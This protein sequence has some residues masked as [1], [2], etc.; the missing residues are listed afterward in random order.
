M[1][2]TKRLRTF[3]VERT[4]LKK[5]DAS[6]AQLHRDRNP[7]VSFTSVPQRLHLCKA[8]VV[9]LLKQ[10]LPPKEIHINLGENLFKDKTLPS[11]LQDLTCVKVFWIKTD[12]GPA[13]K[14]LPALERFEKTDQLLVICDDDMYY[15]NDL[16]H[17]L[18]EADKSSGGSNCY[19]ING[20]QLPADLK[21]ES[22]PSDKAIRSGIK[23]VAIIEGCGGYTLRAAFVDIAALKNITSAPARAFFDDDFWLSGHLSR[24]GIKK[25]QI[26]AGRRKSLLNTVES[27]ISGD[28]AQ[29]QTDLMAHFKN[30][31][32]L[33]EIEPQPNL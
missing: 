30:D 17:T 12:C 3:W 2:L 31:W 8:T 15:A 6:V 29:L 9:S 27:A 11:F 33:D 22:R 16:L 25:F 14:F 20:L 21:S 10:T 5:L 1:S 18:A 19:C 32:A 28:R 4:D 13:T 7:V 24:R 26:P 23:K